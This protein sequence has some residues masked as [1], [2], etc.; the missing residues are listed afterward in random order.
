MTQN[1]SATPFPVAGQPQSPQAPSGIFGSRSFI[2]AFITVLVAAVGLNFS[3][4]YLQLHFKKAAV[5]LRGNFKKD[6]PVR[7]G[8]WVQVAREDTLDPDVQTALA[9]DEF[10]FCTY[11]NAR[12]LNTTVDDLTT[13]F[14]GKSIKEQKALV[15]KYRMQ[16]ATA[17][18]S[19]TFTYYTGKA[20]T[21]AH[22][23]ERC[24][25]G[26]GFDPV[27]PQ[28]EQW[29]LNRSL[30]VR[31]ITFESQSSQA[32][33]FNVAYFFHVNGRY[34]SDNFEVRRQLQN[35]F[36]RYGYY[37]KVETLCITSDRLAAANSMQ[38]LLAQLLP[39][40]E[41]VLPNW[42]DYQSK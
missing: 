9:T 24:Y 41:K 17:V 32:P 19:I 11:L 42:S 6:I 4:S 26:G 30:D 15:D 31:Y 12:A 20:D 28:T 39:H 3:V 1:I 10:L 34:T 25:V 40:V 2:I 35:L 33:P 18:V 27:N 16:N 23:P 5:P 38:S 29:G 14:A 21:V 37:A 8:Q 22:I 13:K 36:N 7:V